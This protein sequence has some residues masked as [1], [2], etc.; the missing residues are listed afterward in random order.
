MEKCAS[1]MRDR[2]NETLG[3]SV[4]DG[5][6]FRTVAWQ[7]HG[8]MRVTRN[9]LKLGTEGKGKTRKA[10]GEGQR[11]WVGWCTGARWGLPEPLGTQG[12]EWG[13]FPRGRGSWYGGG[14]RGP[15]RLLMRMVSPGTER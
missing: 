3:M 13:G 12:A 14:S 5:K 15:G 8:M 11:K 9:M 6:P 2:M 1:G 4:T 7:E 10:E